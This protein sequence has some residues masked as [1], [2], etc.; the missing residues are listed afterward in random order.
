MF[1][2]TKERTAEAQRAYTLF[3]G[4]SPGTLTI[5]DHRDGFFPDS[6]GA[7]KE[8]VR[9]L[10]AA[11]Q[12]DLIFTHASHDRHQDH[13]MLSDLSWQ[14]FRDHLILEYEIVKFD[15][16]LSRPNVY[17]PIDSADADDKVSFLIE[18]YRSQASRHWFN[19]DVFTS[20]MGIRGVEC[21]AAS[22]YAEAFY[23]SKLMLGIRAVG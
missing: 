7:V 12:P 21:R 23:G 19:A 9:Q 15:G 13:R 16:D 3:T 10:A 14:E 8:T 2:G 4:D 1:S 22:G 20:L 17:V 11:I 18:A 5:A 6:Y